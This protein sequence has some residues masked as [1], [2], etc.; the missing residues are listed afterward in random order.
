MNKEERYQQFLDR[1]EGIIRGG[2]TGEMEQLGEM[3]KRV[4]KWL[5]NY[6]PE[7]ATAAI[8][9]LDGE[10]DQECRNYLS[11]SEADEIVNEMIPQP[12][13]SLHHILDMLKSSGYATEEP[14]YFNNYALATTMCMILSDSG[15]TLKNELGSDIRPAKADEILRLV[16]KLAIDKLK[17]KDGKFNIRKYFDL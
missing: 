14:P 17:D 7:I 6:E 8:S 4:M 16:Y 11:A 5:I 2:I 9:I 12:Q 1:Y 3:V 10:H 15:E 13:W